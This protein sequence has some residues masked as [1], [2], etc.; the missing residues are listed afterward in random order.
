MLGW[1]AEG[2]VV[3]NRGKCD[4]M[5]QDA[6]G[7][8]FVN[9]GKATWMGTGAKGGTY[10][11]FGKIGLV[12]PFQE[13]YFKGEKMGGMGGSDNVLVVSKEGDDFFFCLDAPLIDQGKVNRKYATLAEPDVSALIGEL[14][15]A[16]RKSDYASVT[17][18]ARKVD[19]HVRNSYK[20]RVA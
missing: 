15:A 18:L 6:T 19:A 2:G 9:F 17:G 10:F 13:S 4:L 14:E 8:T 11:N 5:G 1:R 3:I 20:R 16:A 12:D 7:G